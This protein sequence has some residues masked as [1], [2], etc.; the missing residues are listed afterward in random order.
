LSVTYYNNEN[1]NVLVRSS[2]VG[3]GTT[4]VGVGTYRF[5]ASGQP[6]ETERSARYESNYTVSSGSTSV[7]GITTSDTSALKSVIRVSY[8]NTSAIHQV[9]M[10]QDQIDV[11][12]VQYPF[13]SIGS[14]SGIGTFGGEIVG[15]NAYLNFYPDPSVGSDIQVQS[16]NEIIYFENDYNNN[17]EQLD[18]GTVSALIQLNA[19]DAVNGNRANRLDFDVRYNG[20][21]IFVK[22]FNPSNS[23]VLE[24]ATGTFSITNHFFSTGEELY[25]EPGST[26]VG[27]GATGVGIGLTENYVGIVTNILPPVVYAIKVNESQFRL[28]TKK[29]YANAGIAVTFTSFGSGNAHTLEMVKK[30]EKSIIS[31]NGVVQKPLTFVPISYTLDNNFGQVGSAT[32]YF[33][34]SGI[35]SVT[36]KDILKINDEYMR[37][38]SVGLG[39]TNSGPIT[40]LGTFPLIQVTRGFVGSSAT[41]HLDG[42]N[43]SIYRG[44]YNIAKNKIWFTEAPKGN[45]RQIRDRSNI[46][47]SKTSF[48]GRV[49]LRNDYRTNIIY[50]DI[51]DQFTGIGQ[52]YTL[53]VQGINTTGIETG[54]G[55]LFL[56]DIFQTP[57][58]INNAGN[59]FNVGGNAGISSV[60]FTGITSSNGQIVISSADIN[61]NQ[62]PRGGVIIS[63]GSTSGAGFAPLVAA[64][65]TAVV[66]AGGSIVSV[67]L[68]TLDI[69]GS[70]YRD[71]V[72]IAVTDSNHTGTPANISAIVGAGGTLSFVINNGGS[73]YS[74]S[75]VQ[76]DV[77][78]PSYEN[79]SVVG[80]FRAGI[81]TTTET[82]SNLLIT[83]DVGPISTTGIGS[84]LFEVSS[85]KISRPGYG[86]KVGDRFKPVGLVTSAGLNSPLEDFELTVLDIFTDSF[87]FWQFGELDYIDSIK[88]LQNGSRTRFP[89]FYNGQL[90]SFE[91][92]PS[93]TTSASIDLNAVLLI[94]I[95]GVIQQPGSAYSFVGGSS[96]VF[97]N[98]PRSEDNISIF[99]YRGTR[100]SDS[101]DVN[102]NETIKLG[103]SVQ[104][105]SNNDYPTTITQN[106]RDITNILSSD[107][108]ETNLYTEQGIDDTFFKP[109]TWIKQKRDKI[110]NGDIVS[111]E[112]DSLESQI[113]PTAKIIKDLSVGDTEIF[114]DDSIFFNYEENN[115]SVVID[116]VNGLIVQ[117]VDP[118]SAA[119]TATV[120]GL[121]TISSLN[122]NDGGSG[123]NGSET[124]KISAPRSIGVGIGTTALASITIINGSVASAN[125]INEGLGYLTENPPQ[126]LVSY[127]DIK[128]EEV[129]NISVI[130]GFSGIITGIGTTSGTA[131]NTLGLKFYIQGPNGFV[132]LSSGYPILIKDTSVG[133][134]LTSLNDS[135]PGII[136]IGTENLDNIYFISKISVFGDNAE[137]DTNIKDDSNINGISTSGSVLSP[138]GRY[139]WGKL[140][141]LNRSASPI[142]IGVSGLT[143]DSGL[144]TFPS[145][146]RRGFGLRDTGAIR[147]QSNV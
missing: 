8:G 38:V 41:T 56:N 58:T 115:Y 127:P 118:V 10:I 99:F 110:I 111:K 96:F 4:A 106:I 122:I 20:N 100:G 76:I 57:T 114:V 147:K 43:I 50:D 48:N 25:Y 85:F 53:T 59:N 77:S 133:T 72:S 123:Y 92:D 28:S 87:S 34:S 6:K 134:G 70:G 18:Y 101:F 66:G 138:V 14:T 86:F 79:L 29:E 125:I 7:I 42:S 137:I 22:T 84:T 129:T 94:F 39:T 73:G 145:I 17:P 124:I 45:P 16:F 113:Y 88:N 1:N 51:S 33:A 97:S 105:F 142:A 128:I 49:Y 140:S 61:Q 89:L 21:P 126:V 139:S 36:P 5:L 91:I 69:F 119:I 65:V 23:A 44:A 63:L 78:Q 146:Q 40:G 102:V 132:G 35:S 3:F 121:G 24:P 103:D 120:S 67:G 13:L 19:Y 75:T 83:L 12:T 60:N 32:S 46:P 141:N 93:D 80:T 144:T 81:G 112:R 37:V 131:G 143:I 54:S 52:T 82:G 55:I 71:P 68:G 26:F 62:L 109:I 15:S 107:T 116:S 104:V 117:A 74:T 9:L 2:I 27:I 108:I 95:N 90:L 30:L 135:G 64:G 31:L 130:Q 98:P 47:F 11:H 136:G